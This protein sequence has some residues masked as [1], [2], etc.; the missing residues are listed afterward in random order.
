MG[1]EKGWEGN[2]CVHNILFIVSQVCLPNYCAAWL[3]AAA[4][5]NRCTFLFESILPRVL[6]RVLVMMRKLFD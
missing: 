1:V 3:L 4:I 6:K 5:W 2:A